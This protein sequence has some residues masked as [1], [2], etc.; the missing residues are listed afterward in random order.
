MDAVTRAFGFTGRFITRRLLDGGR[1]G[2]EA[3]RVA[4]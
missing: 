2:D 3:E 4:R 1:E